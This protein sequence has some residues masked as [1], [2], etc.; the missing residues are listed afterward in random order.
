MNKRK[1]AFRISFLPLLVFPILNKEPT[2][3][4]SCAYEDISNIWGYKI[5]EF[6]EKKYNNL[7][8]KKYI[9]KYYK[10]GIMGHRRVV[11][12]ADDFLMMTKEVEKF[13]DNYSVGSIFDVSLTQTYQHNIGEKISLT[14]SA[15]LATSKI[16]KAALLTGDTS[17]VGA[18]E[19]MTVKTSF[20]ESYSYWEE[21]ITTSA[22]NVKL[23]LPNM[24]EGKT[25]FRFSKVACFVKAKIKAS[26]TEEQGIDRKWRKVKNTTISNYYASYYLDD[27]CT[28]VYNDNTFGDK[29]IGEYITNG[30][31]KVY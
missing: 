2:I 6:K 23:N 9:G 26:Y 5:N 15:Q 17:K 21:S 20:E 13:T 28:F 29:T 18:E 19:G 12:F 10:V 8:N 1:F 22:I 25:T 3:K 7:K 4:H 27:L 14:V 24:L 30:T 11:E 31:I 16:I